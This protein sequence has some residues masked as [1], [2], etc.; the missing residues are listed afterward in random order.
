LDFVL[1]GDNV[2]RFLDLWKSNQ[3]IDMKQKMKTTLCFQLVAAQLS[4]SK[5]WF[6]EGE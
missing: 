4:A 6:D 1:Q 2:L 3:A 5:E